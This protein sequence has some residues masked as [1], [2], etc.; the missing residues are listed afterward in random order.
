[1]N[2]RIIL[3]ALAVI[4]T[5]SAFAAVGPTAPAVYRENF[6]SELQRN[7]DALRGFDNPATPALEGSNNPLT[8]EILDTGW[9]VYAGSAASQTPDVIDFGGSPNPMV[10]IENMGTDSVIN[11]NTGMP[12]NFNL[13]ISPKVERWIAYTE[14]YQQI[15]IENLKSFTFDF[16]KRFD[17]SDY[18]MRLVLKIEDNWY[19]SETAL[20]TSLQTAGWYTYNWTLDGTD[21]AE[22]PVVLPP[23]VSGPGAST[24]LPATG[25][26]TGFG[27][28]LPALTDSNFYLDNFTVYAVVP[29]PS[30]IAMIALGLGAVGFIAYRR[31]R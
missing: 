19:V 12:Y 21:W 31:R 24:T 27:I 26:V 3:S 1:M 16:R 29:E 28:Y 30:T 8:R 11:P 14:E 5:T 9:I 15:E 13:F 4:T 17:N 23:N 18:D 20:D 6:E 22:M 7:P 2:A 10:G 25:T